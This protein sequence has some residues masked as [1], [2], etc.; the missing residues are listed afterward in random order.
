MTTYRY[1]YVLNQTPAYG[2]SGQFPV[3]PYGI[4]DTYQHNVSAVF[5]QGDVLEVKVIQGSGASQYTRY[6]GTAGGSTPDP[7]SPA[8][9]NSN[10]TTTHANNTV[11]SVTWGNS[12]ASD[13]VTVWYFA[14]S[15]A[16]NGQE[17]YSGKFY[18]KKVA[19]QLSVS[20]T[21]VA[22][23]GSLTFTS[24]NATLGGS[25]GDA[26]VQTGTRQNRLYVSLF[27]SSN[28]VVPQGVNGVTWDD[29]RGLSW[30]QVGSTDPNVVA[31]FG[32]GLAN[33]T[34]TAY[35]THLNTATE[36]NGSTGVGNRFYGSEQR[37]GSGVTFTLG[38]VADSTPDAFTMGANIPN[39]G[40]N[41]VITST[42][43]TPVGYN[44][45]TA[46]SVNS[47]SS[48]S[49]SGGA[50]TTS[51]GTISPGQ[52]IRVRRTTTSAYSTANNIFLAVGGVNGGNTTNS[53]AFL[54]ITTIAAPSAN[55]TPAAFG[56]VANGFSSF[57]GQVAGSFKES[58]VVTMS[59]TTAG[60]TSSI[61]VGGSGTPQYRYRA[62]GGSFNAYTATSGNIP[63]GYQFQFRVTTSTTP[64]AQVSGTLSI[65]GNAGARTGTITLTAAAAG[66]SNTGGSGAGT[67]DYGLEVRNAAGLVTF[68]PSMRTSNFINASTQSIQIAGGGV[69]SNLSAEGMTTNY[70]T[71]IAVLID[72]PGQ[73]SFI[74]DVVI[75]RGSGIFSI[76]NPGFASVTLNWMVVRY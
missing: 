56:T 59:G 15:N 5:K 29:N 43:F 19:A 40:I 38:A 27:N 21:S 68:S 14:S 25:G 65:S 67:G 61:Q 58:N 24:N 63:A 39:A 22:P 23:G 75:G 49:I 52:S 3:A 42:S 51:N 66:S 18:F 20:A 7:T 69:V 32:S 17:L 53:S 16:A 76:T 6:V 57:A 74:P 47:G 4:N 35:L 37:L 50:F 55:T 44:T 26:F 36:L 13:A 46:I 33:G 71:D 62:V 70:S 2:A 48:Y 10:S 45:A 54:T 12:L 73:S 60:T 1:N 9:A 11:F 64:G 72:T 31:T 34:Y 8:S 28:V 41:T 30:G